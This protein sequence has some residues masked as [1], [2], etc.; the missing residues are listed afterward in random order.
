[1]KNVVINKLGRFIFTEE[2][3]KAFWIRKNVEL[4]FKELTNDQLMNLAIVMMNKSSHSEL[5]QHTLEEGWRNLSE[6]N[7]KMIADDDTHPEMHV[8]LID[9]DLEGQPSHVIIDRLLKMSCE[10]CNFSF[11]VEEGKT[12]ITGLKCPTCHQDTNL[13]SQPRIVNKN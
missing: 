8:E 2:H 13:D 5:E 1:M 3:L 11:Y 7:G 6:I 12:D 4:A 10:P 9:T